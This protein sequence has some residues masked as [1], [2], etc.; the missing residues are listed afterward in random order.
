MLY[1]AQEQ[2][3]SRRFSGLIFCVGCVILA[4]GVYTGEHSTI[5]GAGLLFVLVIGWS[6]CLSLTD[7]AEI[8]AAKINK[9]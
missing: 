1:S 2:R 9:N 6:I 4:R 3:A 7:A 5:L 8:I